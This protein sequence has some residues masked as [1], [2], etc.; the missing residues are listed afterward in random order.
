MSLSL[1]NKLDAEMSQHSS[2]CSSLAERSAGKT[3]IRYATIYER[4]GEPYRFIV[5]LLF[6]LARSLNHFLF[7]R[8]EG[9][10]ITFLTASGRC[11]AIFHDVDPAA[12]AVDEDLDLQ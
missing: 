3:P 10:R 5:A 9:G 11:T 2:S 4:A 6:P 8:S 7:R 1:A 12:A